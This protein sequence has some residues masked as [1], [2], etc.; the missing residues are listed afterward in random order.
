LDYR[1]LYEEWNKQRGDRVTTVE[2]VNCERGDAEQPV[3]T[4]RGDA[5]RK[6]RWREKN[7]EKLAEDERL[8]RKKPAEP[9]W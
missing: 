9:T 7:R 1:N 3:E 5:D 4:V 6:A 2:T 8:R